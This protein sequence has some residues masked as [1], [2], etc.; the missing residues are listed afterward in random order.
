MSDF[1]QFLVSWACATY[2]LDYVQK[3]WKSRQ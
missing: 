3:L 2:L 1:T